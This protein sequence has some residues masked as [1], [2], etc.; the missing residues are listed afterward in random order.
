VWKE[1]GG[2]LSQLQTLQG[3]SASND[4]S[5][6]V[7][8]ALKSRHSC[9]RWWTSFAPAPGGRGVFGIAP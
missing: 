1:R 5:A 9:A 2:G 8:N 6:H 7:E 3:V 4:D